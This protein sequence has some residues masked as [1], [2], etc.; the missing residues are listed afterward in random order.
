MTKVPD[1]QALINQSQSQ[2]HRACTVLVVSVLRYPFSDK[3][4]TSDL[5]PK[6]SDQMFINLYFLWIS[7]CINKFRKS[8]HLVTKYI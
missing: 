1:V 4:K 3:K 5:Q 6:E 2:G 8:P 7:L